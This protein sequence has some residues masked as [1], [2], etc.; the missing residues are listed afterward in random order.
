MGDE[1]YEKPERGFT[2]FF[3]PVEWMEDDRLIP[4]DWLILAEIDALSKSKKS[5]VPG[6]CYA[7]NRHIGEFVGCKE[8]WVGERCSKLKKIGYVEQRFNGRVMLRKLRNVVIQ[9][10]SIG[11]GSPRLQTESDTA[12]G[13]R[14]G[15]VAKGGSP[16]PQT[17]E[18]IKERIKYEKKGAHVNNFKNGKRKSR[19]EIIS[20]YIKEKGTKAQRDE[21][22][23]NTQ[24]YMQYDKNALPSE[25]EMFEKIRNQIDVKA[26][27]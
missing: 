27:C 16:R 5:K 24:F 4:I 23:N 25:R 7:S 21:F 12:L 17:E 13:R 1:P 2:G 6:W 26:V 14:Q 8:K 3:I 18:S 15:A 20:D 9:P 22:F 10:T 19:Y 11:G